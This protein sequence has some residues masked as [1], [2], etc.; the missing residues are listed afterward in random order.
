MCFGCTGLLLG[1]AICRGADGCRRPCASGKHPSLGMRLHRLVFVVFFIYTISGDRRLPSLPA[2]ALLAPAPHPAVLA[3]ADAPTRLA[4]A[5]PPA[6][7]ADAGTPAL[8]AHAPH[9]YYRAPDGFISISIFSIHY[10]GYHGTSTL[11]T[12]NDCRNRILSNDIKTEI[13]EIT[14]TSII[15]SCTPT[16]RAFSYS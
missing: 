13:L 6:M 2:F 14:E 7:L 15:N 9:P 5:P 3:D 4:H 11:V 1:G 10:R 8:L 12:R 16:I